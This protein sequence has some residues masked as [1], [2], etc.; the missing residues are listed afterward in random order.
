MQIRTLD[1]T[2]SVALGRK[3]AISPASTGLDA[4]VVITD[5]FYDLDQGGDK[6]VVTGTNNL[7]EYF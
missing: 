7:A 4:D 2:T 5:V 3:L 6:L 1:L